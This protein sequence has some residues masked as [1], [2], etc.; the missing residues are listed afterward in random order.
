MKLRHSLSRGRVSLV[1]RCFWES[2]FIK[3][4]TISLKSFPNVKIDPISLSE[5]VVVVSPGHFY[6][7]RRAILASK[8]PF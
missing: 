7:L 1:L 6:P 3:L 8:K 5:E 4:L 2:F